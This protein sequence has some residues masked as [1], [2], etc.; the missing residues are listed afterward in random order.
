VFER[1][2]EAQELQYMNGL[3]DDISDSSISRIDSDNW[4]P[5][6]FS[7]C[8]PRN[9]PARITFTSLTA[10]VWPAIPGQPLIFNAKYTITPGPSLLDANMT[11]NFVLDG[12][13]I[14]FA[15]QK[16]KI[17]DLFPFINDF[18]Y[19][20]NEDIRGVWEAGQHS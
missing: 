19:G 2:D 3:D 1:Q 16:G 5:I 10:N 8:L 20:Q 18:S 6:S 14:E 11:C 13:N 15:Q 9:T 7:N 17:N 4:K 12:R